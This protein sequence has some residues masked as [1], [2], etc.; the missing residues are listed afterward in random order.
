MKQGGG[1]MMIWGYVS[2]A[3]AGFVCLGG[4]YETPVNIE[5]KPSVNFYKASLL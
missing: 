4:C 1:R 3:A 5:T 2:A